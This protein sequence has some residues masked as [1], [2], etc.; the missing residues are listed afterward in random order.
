[1]KLKIISQ[2]EGTQDQEEWDCRLLERQV[3]VEILEVLVWT[4]HTHNDCVSY[5]NYHRDRAKFYYMILLHLG[6]Y[7]KHFCT[8]NGDDEV[9]LAVQH[10]TCL[11]MKNTFAGADSYC[12]HG[13]P[14]ALNKG[15]ISGSSI[16]I[17]DLVKADE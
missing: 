4:T 16:I 7:G 11:I 1:M 8:K 10:G 15:K 6:A 3:W 2:E 13:V 9:S 17:V 5:Q 14:V 12:T